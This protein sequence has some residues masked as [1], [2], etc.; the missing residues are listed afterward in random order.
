[1]DSALERRTFEEL[2]ADLDGCTIGDFFNQ[3][4]VDNPIG[5]SWDFHRNENQAL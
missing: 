1:M 4:F 5:P 2:V 3:N